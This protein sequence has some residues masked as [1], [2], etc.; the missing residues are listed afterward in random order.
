MSGQ[1]FISYRREES[2]WSARSLYDRLC[3]R[4]DRKQIFMDIDAIALGDDFVKAIEKTVGECDVLVAVIG[5]HW[6]TS[7]DEKGDRRL[8]NSE[9]FVR[10][11][12]GTALQRDIR[13]IPVLVDSASMPR[14]SELPDDLKPLVRRNALRISD[15]GFDDDCRR[16]VAA[17][18]QVLEKTTA[19]RREREEKERQN[20]GRGEAEAKERLETERWRKEQQERLEHKPHSMRSPLAEAQEHAG[21]KN[22]R[23]K[24][25]LAVSTVA[26]IGLVLVDVFFW[27]S[28]ITVQRSVVSPNPAGESAVKSAVVE[29]ALV[30]SWESLGQVRN[31][32][33]HLE[34]IFNAAGTFSRRYF[35]DE[36]GAIEAEGGKYKLTGSKVAPAPGGTYRFQGS[37]TMTWVWGDPIPV[38][39]PIIL[40]RVGNCEYPQDLF[41]GRW[42]SSLLVQG[43][44]WDWTMEIGR[45]R[46]Y[47]SHLEASDDGPFTA[48]DGKWQMISG[49]ATTPISGAYQ[50][51]TQGDPKLNI[52]PYGWIILKRSQKAASK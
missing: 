22:A 33:M 46:N 31:F 10:R 47:H 7:K 39:T 34:F 45:E 15:T 16:L 30:G 20:T 51:P 42:R 38:A 44:N 23:R 26:T 35:L 40:T 17:I 25:L 8:D 32:T 41:V 49:W 1:I 24:I 11:E 5:T 19:E 36:T 13:V 3:A 2:R 27:Q 50:I 4:F 9:D 37:D 29:P 48:A 21:K 12:I 14:A 28:R 43:A 52:W 6:L 18:E